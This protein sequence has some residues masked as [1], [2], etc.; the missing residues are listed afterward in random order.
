MLHSTFNFT[1]SDGP[2]EKNG[3]KPRHPNLATCEHNIPFSAATYRWLNEPINV[4][5]ENAENV[6]RVENGI[7]MAHS[8][9]RHFS[10]E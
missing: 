10:N 9:K 1:L 4:P 8:Q 2:P 5:K 6:M 7:R 3:Q